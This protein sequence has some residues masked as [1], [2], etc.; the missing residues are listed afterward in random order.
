MIR[1]LKTSIDKKIAFEI[2]KELKNKNLYLANIA[3]GNF[4]IKIEPLL[5]KLFFIFA[6]SF[7]SNKEELQQEFIVYFISVLKKRGTPTLEFSIFLSNAIEIFFKKKRW[8]GD[9]LSISPLLKYFGKDISNIED[10]II[11]ILHEEKEF[12]GMGLED[13]KKELLS[14]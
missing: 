12:I 11:S 7:K 14:V 3:L 10:R 13:L 9:E 1:S 5:D 2:Y 6:K 4:L 8:I